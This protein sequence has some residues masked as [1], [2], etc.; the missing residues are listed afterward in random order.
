MDFCPT[1]HFPLPMR[2]VG[3]G[4]RHGRWRRHEATGPLHDRRCAV[5]SLEL[6]AESAFVESLRI[7]AF[8][9]ALEEWRTANQSGLAR[10]ASASPRKCEGG[11]I[12]N[13]SLWTGTNLVVSSSF[14]WTL[15]AIAV[16][17]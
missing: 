3:A 11:G 2:P 4:V 7:I 13:G 17:R 12:S 14:V 6:D 15:L 8:R 9:I 16:K 10:M 5:K 1:D